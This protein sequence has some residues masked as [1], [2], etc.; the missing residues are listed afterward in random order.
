[1]VAELGTIDAGKY[2]INSLTLDRGGKQVLAASDDGTVK[3]LDIESLSQVGE[4]SGHEGPVQCVAA[5][6][7]DGYFISGS[8][9]ATF[10][11]WSK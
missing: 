5:A 10:R 7:N 1:M 11:I 2:P 3:V 4:L 9:D 6:P 8:S